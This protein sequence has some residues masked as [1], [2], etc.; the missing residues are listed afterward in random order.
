MRTRPD[1]RQQAAVELEEQGG[2]AGPVGAHQGHLLPM[3]DP[4]GDP[5]QHLGA[6]RVGIVQV[7]HLNDMM[8]HL[9]S[10]IIQASPPLGEII[11]SEQHEQ[12]GP[13]QEKNYIPAVEV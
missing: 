4:E 9:T 13:S 6:V 12:S 1:G 2:L 7:F 3:G 10:P 5:L 8:A 11:K